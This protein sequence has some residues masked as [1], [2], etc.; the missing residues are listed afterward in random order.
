MRILRL[1]L[2][3]FGPFTDVTLDFSAGRFGLHVVYGAN[4]AGKTSAL[5]AL[6]NLL[7]GIP[8]Q[9]PDNFRHPYAALR[10]GAT[11][12]SSDGRRIAFLRRKAARNTLLAPDN[13]TE[14]EEEVLAPFLGSVDRE[15][16]R[17][18]FGLGHAELVQGGEKIVQG[19]SQVGQVLF[20]A[21]AAIAD[22]CQIQKRLQ[23]QA[24]ALYTPRGRNPR[25]NEALRKLDEA[26]RRL[27][28]GQLL[29]EQWA[30]HHRAI[31]QAQADLA[32]LDDQ[33]RA[34]QTE[35]TRLDRLR[36]ALGPAARRKDLVDKLDT[37]ASVTVLP[38]DFPERRRATLTQLAVAE[39]EAANAQRELQRIEGELATLSVFHEAAAIDE[40]VDRLGAHRKAQRDLPRLKEQRQAA[41]QRLAEVL[42]TLRPDLSPDL[43]DTLLLTVTQQDRIQRLA[44]EYTRLST[45]LETARKG[46]ADRQREAEEAEQALAALPA[47]PDP[48]ALHAALRAAQSEGDLEARLGEHQ[49]QIA[50]LTRDAHS[51]LRRLGLWSGPWEALE[52]L[53]LPVDETLDRF[54]RLMREAEQALARLD[55]EQQAKRK[56]YDRARR[57]LE[58][59]AL[60]GDVPTEAE[61]DAARGHR[62]AGW[63]LIRAAW[64]GPGANPDRWAQYLGRPATPHDLADAFSRSI[65]KADEL[66]DRLRRE[67]DRVAK[68]AQL[69]ALSKAA[70]EELHAAEQRYRQAAGHLEQLRQAWAAL[71][72][73]AGIQPLNP[74]EMR[75]WM[76][77]YRELLR[78]IQTLRE[79][80]SQADA[81]CQKIELHRRSLAER[82][83]ALGA[84]GAVASESLAVLLH[85][86]Q[87]LLETLQARTQQRQRLEAEIQRAR[88]QLQQAEREIQSAQEGLRAW[89]DQWSMALEPLGLDSRTPPEAALAVLHS[90]HELR[91]CRRKMAELDERIQGINA[92]ARQFARDVEELC[93]RVA[94]DLAGRPVE[95]AVR[96]LQERLH[97]GRTDERRRKELGDEHKRW[98]QKR[99]K[100]ERTLATSRA[101]LELLCREAECPSPDDLLQAEQASAEKARLRDELAAIE[102]RLAE[103]AGTGS[104]EALLGELASL[105]ADALPGRIE[106]LDQELDAIYQ[107]R[108]ALQ[109]ALGSHQRALEEMD[110]GPSAAEIA[111]E[112]EELRARLEIDASQFVRL[113]LGLAVLRQAIE[114]YREKHEGPVLRRAGELFARLTCGSF[115]G[116]VV[117]FDD[118]GQSVLKGVRA[119]GTERV[120]LA[121]MSDGTADQLF[122]ALRLASLEHYLQGKEPWPLVLDDVLVGFDDRRAAA[123]LQ[124]LAELSDRTQVIFFTHHAHLVALA[125]HTVPANP[126]RLFVHHLG[127]EA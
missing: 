79:H 25:I 18:M 23:E 65:T 114:R 126:Q 95:E 78:Q 13:A 108:D 85:R 28:Q 50:R 71:W 84:D 14:L 64:L 74:P 21:G 90:L 7:F 5:R 72:K 118:Q 112:I 121:A 80:Q 101:A 32:A 91:E 107:R 113:R 69:V 33:R 52:T 17:T 26:R 1:D 89:E 120:E 124:V 60:E 76:G 56:Q 82:L 12:E 38:P 68:Q 24:E 67:A 122:L 35:R 83:A 119:G 2:R 40:L 19:S 20:A 94:P 115:Q 53:P 106:Q 100:A 9:S 93:G 110:A 34:L 75:A 57:D 109:Q 8:H 99:E 97:K 51:A 77:R 42:A 55:E 44:Q 103:L 36:Q 66:A 30:E 123:A 125:Q 81:L 10:I 92:D 47:A 27:R 70:Q 87:D 46:A 6:E 96:T 102:Q 48:A 105:D 29:A 59:M 37:L 45:R 39:G 22:L 15:G 98:T 43:A 4:E 61:L 117:D 104:I 11:L 16:F 127:S 41:A 58:A 62:D 54:D 86:S 3:A 73:P 88:T 111:E 63:E 49:R 116:L 31:D